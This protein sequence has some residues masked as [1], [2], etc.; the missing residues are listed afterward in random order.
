MIA[1]RPQHWDSVVDVVVVGSGGAGLVAATLAHDGGAEVVVLEKAPLIG[2]TTG[3]SGGVQWI[4]GNHHMADV[5]E[6]DSREEALTYIRRVTL[7][8]E[9]PELVD[10]YLDTAPEMLEYLE[11]KTPLRMQVPPT[12][13][14]YYAQFA[15][16]KRRGRSIEPAPFDARTELGDEAK[17][18]RTSPHL[19][20]L[21]LTD[22][23]NLGNGEI[24]ED[25]SFKGPGKLQLEAITTPGRTVLGE[26][27][28]AAKREAEDVRVLGSAMIAA[29]YKGLRNR[30][31]EIHTNS[32]VRDLVVVDGSVIGVAA[33]R[34]G[35]R[36][37][38]GARKAVILACGGFE[39]S[40][41]MVKTFIGI[42][43]SAISPPYNEGD[44]HQM[45]ME[46]GAELANMRSF[47]G[48]PVIVEPGFM[49][50][51]RP[52]AQMGTL[53]GLPGAIVVNR[54]GHRF[55][56]EGVTYRDFPKVLDTYDPVSIDYPNEGPNWVIF[57]QTLKDTSVILP[58]VVPS[59]PA[60]EWIT[61][62]PS[63]RELAERIDIDPDALESTVARWNTQVAA[64]DDTDY[65]RGTTYFEVLGSGKA[66][67]ADMVMGP[68][69]QG[70]FYAIELLNGAIGTNGGPRID[71]DG[72]VR[73]GRG[74]VIPGLYAAGNASACVW[75]LAYP[76]G[77]ATIGPAATFGYI[78]GRHAAS[79]PS[80]DLSN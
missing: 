40:E 17:R 2:G 23:N 74:G 27:S 3:I 66:P 30:N 52:V 9:D 65:R 68:I 18:V 48:I 75:G 64:H 78:A 43:I 29:L 31:V 61:R 77:G 55:V 13:A 25:D 70:P 7:G 58:S 50:D 6:T 57:D 56:N 21:T 8:R 45:A 44:G 71:R 10:A 37:L 69:E 19:P 38:V 5:G 63:I 20:W 53:R 32:P 42:P 14:D 26:L 72:R 49:Y 15:G 54:H 35:Q 24:P 46:A 59:Q 22:V 4:P 33:E 11:A 80:R 36:Q 51:G 47:W 79:Q 1:S 41:S 28:L 39:W 60:P 76:G 73:R 67:T 16:G 12:F 34:D 62:A